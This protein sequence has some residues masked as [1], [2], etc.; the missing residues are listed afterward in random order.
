MGD[1]VLHDSVALIILI[2][3]EA[4]ID[5][6]VEARQKGIT[7]TQIEGTNVT[8]LPA[9][10]DDVGTSQEE[11]LEVGIFVVEDV[12]VEQRVVGRFGDLEF[13]ED[14]FICAQ[15]LPQLD[16][17]FVHEQLHLLVLALLEV[18]HHH[19]IQRVVGNREHHQH[20]LLPHKPFG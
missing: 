4:L 9:E 8:A 17:S 15:E 14:L 3:V 2:V 6:K 20:D 1:K 13:D 10:M 16:I 12:Q 5:G 18:S 11:V 19:P 7:L